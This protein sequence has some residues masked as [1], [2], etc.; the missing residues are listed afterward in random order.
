MDPVIQFEYGA[1]KDILRDLLTLIVGVLVFSVTFSEKIIDHRSERPLP[2]AAMAIA[3]MSLLIGIGV[4]VFAYAELLDALSVASLPRENFE[5][6]LGWAKWE[7]AAGAFCLVGALFWIAG[8][9][10]LSL[11]HKHQSSVIVSK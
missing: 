3:W 9:A 4:C 2:R 5:H 7:L 8:A 11:K 1:L 6:Y 10:V